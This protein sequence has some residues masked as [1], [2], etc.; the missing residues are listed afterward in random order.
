[1]KRE[2]GGVVPRKGRM[3]PK[4]RKG[5]GEKA[6]VVE[7]GNPKAGGYRERGGGWTQ[8]DEMDGVDGGRV[9]SWG[10]EAPS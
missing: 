6:K 1:M 7:A 5:R 10:V 2:A 8:M 4:G 9:D 3:G